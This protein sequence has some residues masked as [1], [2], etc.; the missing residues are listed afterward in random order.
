MGTI[1]KASCE[2]GYETNNMYLGGGMTNH[3]TVSMFPNYCKDCKSLF[4]ANMFDENIVCQ[5]CRSIDTVPYNNPSLVK[6]LSITSFDWN[7]GTKNSPLKLSRENSFCPNCEKYSL[8]FVST[9]M[10]D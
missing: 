5:Q 4:Q 10:W 8:K 2:C 6:D 3:T 7:S 9:G 1:I